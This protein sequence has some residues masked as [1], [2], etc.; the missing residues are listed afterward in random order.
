MIAI[1]YIY[2]YLFFFKEKIVTSNFTHYKKSGFRPH[3]FFFGNVSTYA[4]IG[5]LL[6]QFYKT[7]LKN[8]YIYIYIF[9]ATFYKRKLNPDFL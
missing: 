2:L 9:F 8:E 7:L 3:F 6:Q 5:A 4:A 1:F